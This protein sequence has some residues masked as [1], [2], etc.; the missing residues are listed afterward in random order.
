VHVIVV[1]I[2]VGSDVG[3]ADYFALIQNFVDRLLES[4]K[5]P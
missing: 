3:V 1:P 4:E 5:A 2:D